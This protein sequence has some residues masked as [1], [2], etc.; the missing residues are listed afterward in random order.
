MT[1][2]MNKSVGAMADAVMAEVEQEQLAKTAALSHTSGVEVSSALG[3]LL[4]KTAA[5]IREEAANTE[6]SYGDLDKFRKKYDV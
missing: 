6:I 4:V 5:R 2:R 1:R 3:Q